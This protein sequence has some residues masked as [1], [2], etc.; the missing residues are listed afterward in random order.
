MMPLR[1]RPIRERWR[2]TF[3]PFLLA[4]PLLPILGP[5]PQV[6]GVC[7]GLFILGLPLSAWGAAARWVQGI[8]A[9]GAAVGLGF[10]IPFLTDP[11]GGVLALGWAAIP[12]TLAWGV[13]V[14]A[15]REGLRLAVPRPALQLSI[16]FIL[17][18]D[19]LL[20]LLAFPQAQAVPLIRALPLLLLA[21]VLWGVGFA[22]GRHLAVV[23]RSVAFGLVLF[24]IGGMTKGAISLFLLVPLGVIGL[25]MMTTSP[26]LL[27]SGG[28]SARPLVRWWVSRFDVSHEGAAL[29]VVLLVSA[30]ALGGIL[31]AYHSAMMALSALGVLPL[32]ALGRTVA[33]RLSRRATQRSD[34]EPSSRIRVL[35]VG[36]DRG[37][38]ADATARVERML[39]GPPR[40]IVTPNTLSV[41]RAR[42][43]PALQSVY[44]RADL[45]LPDG[46]GVVWASRRLRDALSERV[47][48]V[49]LAEAVL[50]IAAQRGVSVYLLGGRP[51]VAARAAAR[52]SERFPEL[53]IA[54]ARDGYFRDET[55]VWRAIEATGAG[56]L[57][58]GMGVPRQE[59]FM[60]RHALARRGPVMI[61]LGGA[62]D[63]FSGDRARAPLAWRRLGL[64][65]LFRILQEPRRVGAAWAIVWFLLRIGAARV[66]L[67]VDEL[68]ALPVEP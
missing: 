11:A 58:V 10:R 44:D 25:P 28:I 35:G 33:V 34:R 64:E 12:F 15:M 2:A 20:L 51:G 40:I 7:V 6:V 43:D 38:L 52:L 23:H 60:A 42:R 36:F 47:T 67:T 59:R 65:W 8:V 53:A 13:A 37:D 62:L 26:A 17:A 46:I 54:G 19:A 66:G 63:V 21:I 27:A 18:A 16:D 55:A 14:M 30:F 39:G 29:S 32:L 57:L 4:T 22:R 41:L 9:I 50:P 49:D 56:L 1:S 68:L 5:T 48:G 31:A 24:G 45:V 3:I 61:G